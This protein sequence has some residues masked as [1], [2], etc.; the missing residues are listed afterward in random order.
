MK[1]RAISESLHSVVHITVLYFGGILDFM[2]RQTPFRV[3][4]CYGN[5]AASSGPGFR[6]SSSRQK[7][8]GT[9]R[10]GS[11]CNNAS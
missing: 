10:S 4:V 6:A 3:G 2:A 7:A 1:C 11:A 5:L 8:E 9:R